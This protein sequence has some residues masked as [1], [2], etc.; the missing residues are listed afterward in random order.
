MKRVAITS[1]S[2]RREM[3]ETFARTGTPLMVA[4]YRYALILPL[5][6]T[7]TLSGVEH[8]LFTH[9]T[10]IHMTR[11]GGTWPNSRVPRRPWIAGSW[12]DSLAST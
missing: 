1:S 4:F 7:V 3:V 2:P 9:T 10:T 11:V 6:I 8:T 12:A 5:D